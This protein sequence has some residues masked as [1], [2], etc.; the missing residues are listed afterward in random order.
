M[1]VMRRHIRPRPAEEILEVGM[2]LRR[3]VAGQ[4]V[5]TGDPT[6]GGADGVEVRPLLGQPIG[7]LKWSRHDVGG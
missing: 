3:G 6:E 7:D 4:V 5:T 1:V 2:D